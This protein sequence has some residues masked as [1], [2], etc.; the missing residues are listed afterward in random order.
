MR[1][2][3]MRAPR[4]PP[5][6]SAEREA[7]LT[8]GWSWVSTTR[9]RCS[10]STTCAGGRRPTTCGRA[11]AGWCSCTTP[12]RRRRRRGRA[13]PTRRRTMR[14][15][16]RSATRS[17]C[18]PTRRSGVSSTRSTSLTTPSRRQPTR[19]WVAS[20]GPLAPSLSATRAGRSGAA[21]RCWVARM[22]RTRLSPPFTTFGSPSSHGGTLRMRT[23]STRTTR[24]SG[25]RSVGWSGKMKSCG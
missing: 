20:S 21:A 22:R 7:R 3:P 9:T 15:S 17:S 4:A 8:C 5:R 14:C 18:S 19:R 12:T 1:M 16:R 24:A 10:S 2:L 6:R 11:T 25:R 13:H 23:S